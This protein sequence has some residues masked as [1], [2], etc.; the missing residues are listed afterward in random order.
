MKL[1][2]ILSFLPF[3]SFSQTDTIRLVKSYNYHP[4]IANTQLGDIAYWKLCDSNGMQTKENCSILSF[5]MSYFGKNG[6]TEI[7]ISGSTIPDSICTEIGVYGIDNMMF[8][9]N[10]R[11]MS[12]ENYKIM[13]LSSMN[14]MP[15]R[16]EE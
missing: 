7:H 10:I 12:H 1:L 3:L 9:N 8:F 5:D 6:F 14:L 11:A 4:M 15:V 16:R 13:H 2:L